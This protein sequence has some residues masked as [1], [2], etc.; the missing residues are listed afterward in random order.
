[1]R[2]VF[3]ANYLYELPF[4]K[5][6][7]GFAHTALGGWQISSIAQFQTGTPC[8]VIS[9]NDYAG[10]G[11]DGNWDTCGGAGQFW[12]INGD[13]TVVHQFA[14]GGAKDPAQWFSITNS[15]GSPIFTAPEWGRFQPDQ[16]HIRKND[17]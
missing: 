13:P 14:G 16:R 2:H 11:Q 3:I 15:D 12:V 6:G 17:C 4:F 9:N 7:H 5:D 1:M 8:Q 10:V